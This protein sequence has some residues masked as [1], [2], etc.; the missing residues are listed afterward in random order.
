MITVAAPEAQTQVS[1]AVTVTAAA[2]SRPEED[3]VFRSKLPDIEIPR[4]LALHEYCFARASELA[5]APCLIAAA[6]GRTYTYAETR[7][8]CRKA[9][10]ALRGLGVTQGDR[11]MI[12]LPNSVEFVLAFFGASLLGAVATAAN[13]FCTPQEINKQFR[14]SGARLVVTQSAYVD[15]LRHEA[16]PRI[17]SGEDGALTV[18][19]V[20]D[21]AAGSTAEGCVAFWEVVASADEGS[22][23]EVTISP[24]D[25]V[26]LPFSSGTTGLPKG[27]V[28]THG[29]QVAGVAQQVDGANPNLHMG[30]GDVALCVLPLFHIFSLN[31]VLL[32]ALRAGAAVMLMPRFEMGTMLE[33]IARW[34]VT[35]A[36]V[37]PPLVLALAKNP[38]LEAHDLSSIRVVLSGAAPLGRELVDALRARLP[39][40]VFGQVRFQ[41]FG[42]TCS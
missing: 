28:L 7:R 29:G 37:V 30:P 19:A 34:R 11:V 26:A 24:D 35:V 6:T 31:S 18:V 13:P 9:A 36:A 20:D 10:A 42:S 2:M 23:P 17:V 39:Q 15:K 14:A 40:A 41:R 5:D 1:S 21:D 27:V 32:C 38:A 16:F 3:N 4:H 12:L 22:L 8:L 25:P 33:G